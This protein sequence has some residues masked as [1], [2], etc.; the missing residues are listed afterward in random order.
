MNAPRDAL[1]V[2]TPDAAVLNQR[3]L[4][5]MVAALRERLREKWAPAAAPHGGAAGGVAGEA[6]AG[7]A[8]SAFGAAEASVA[9][10]AVA[11]RAAALT[12]PLERLTQRFGLTGFERDLLLLAAGYELDRELRELLQQPPSFSLALAWLP[13]AHW[14]AIAPQRPLRYWRLL[15]RPAEAALLEAPLRIDERILHCL[16]GVAAVDERLLGLASFRAASGRDD[17]AAR[18]AAAMLASADADGDCAP[19]VWIDGKGEVVELTTIAIDAAHAA[20]SA[21]LL[22]SL[23]DVPADP[24]D[25]AELARRLDRE[26]LLAGAAIV[27]AHDGASEPAA[28]ATRQARALIEAIASP[29]L[30]CGRFDSAALH[31]IADRRLRR[32]QADAAAWPQGAAA[33]ARP[34]TGGELDDAVRRAALQFRVSQR[35][36]DDCLDRID[37]AAIEPTAD[38]LWRLLREASRGGLDQLAQRVDARTGLADIVLPP[39]QQSQLLEIA[40]QLRN[41]H[42]VYQDWGFGERGERGLGIAALFSG[43]SGTGKTM[44]AEA[45]ANHVGLDLYRIDLAHTVSK[46]IGE[47]EKN[48]ARI[49]DAAEASGAVLLFDEADA[50]FGK[51]SE[52]K[53]SHD[54]YANIEVAYL[55]QRIEAYSGL[56]ILTT[57]LKSSLDR[58]FQRRIRFI[59]NFPFPDEAA[60]RVLWQRQWPERAP[61]GDVDAEAL[62]RLPLAGGHIRSVALNAAFLAAEAGEAIAMKHIEL[63][64]QREAAKLERSLPDGGAFMARS[65]V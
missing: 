48:L 44:A 43:E 58:A 32:V 42:T 38:Q 47:T 14:D 41:R 53:D 57:N 11:L 34:A 2:A 20:G 15:E 4:S 28:E 31:D 18:H 39:S 5:A 6:D 1:P 61:L 29:V 27:L 40:A 9:D 51:R 21:A 62:A 59:V 37:P 52:V 3:W 25:R 7:G 33:R 63:A 55:L 12:T 10:A 64:T 49:F 50:L 13:D 36:L 46:Y 56:A 16:T 60:R 8:G 17:P 65:R 22:V 26:A 35:V 45:I 30:A 54:R 24:R 23:A 19:L